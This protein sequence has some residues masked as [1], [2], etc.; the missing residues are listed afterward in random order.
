MI[1]PKNKE[2]M[3]IFLIVDS[4][5]LLKNLCAEKILLHLNYPE[6]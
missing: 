4:E 3:K 1:T 2:V 6:N 5:R